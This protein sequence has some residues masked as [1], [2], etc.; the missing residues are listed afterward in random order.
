MFLVS[1]PIT[2]LAQTVQP[3]ADFSLQAAIDYALKHNANYLN[4]ELDVKLAQY[5]NKEVLGM[6]LPQIGASADLKDYLIYERAKYITKN[7]YES[8]PSFLINNQGTRMNGEMLNSRL[9][10]L[11]KLTKNYSLEQK[12]ITLHCLRHSIATHLMDNG[13]NIEFVQALL[14]HAEIDTAHLYSKRR[15]QQLRNKF[16]V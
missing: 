1:A 15:K 8:N 9:K 13:A 12:E 7:N 4:A 16:L 14:G 3:T 5:K 6:G 11:I 10:E 2:L